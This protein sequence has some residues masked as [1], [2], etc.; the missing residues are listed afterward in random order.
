MP[1]WERDYKAM[2]EEMFFGDMP[3]FAELTG[4]VR[5]FERK[6]NSQKTP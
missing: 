5:D 6:L 2:R 3:S 4:V 1:D